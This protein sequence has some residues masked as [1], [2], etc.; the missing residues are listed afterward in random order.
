MAVV[1]GGV[2]LLHISNY[3]KCTAKRTLDSAK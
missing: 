3:C 2:D 1:G